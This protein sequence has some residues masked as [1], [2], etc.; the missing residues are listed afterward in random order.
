ML[1]WIGW[2]RFRFE[3]RERFEFGYHRYLV[4][5]GKTD[6]KKKVMVGNGIWI[7]TREYLKKIGIGDFSDPVVSSQSC[8]VNRIRDNHLPNCQLWY[9]LPTRG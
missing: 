5:A 7:S 3:T 6:H 2:H 8:P 1:K 4:T 9:G